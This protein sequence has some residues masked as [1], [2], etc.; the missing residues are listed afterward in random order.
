[1]KNKEN[2][3]A[4]IDAWFDSHADALVRDLGT[5]IAV[6]SVRG[7]AL[8]GKPYGEG[9][10]AAL[11]AAGRI[12]EEKGFK[13]VNF[14]NHVVTADLN[15]QE[16]TL[17]ILAHLDTVTV[18]E[19]WTSDPFTLQERGGALYG[20][21]VIDDKGPA[22]AAIHALEA[23][24]ALAPELTKGCRLILGSAEETGHDDLAFYRK[25]N[26]MP[27]SVFTPDA[28]YPVVNLEKGRFVPT[29]GAAWA[30]SSATPCVVSVTGGATA[31]VVPNHA[32]AVVEGLPLAY[33]Q[34]RC[35]EYASK[36]HTS[37]SAAA[38]HD[39]VKITASGVASHAMMP[40]EGLNAQTALLAV[41]SELPLHNCPALTCIK[42]LAELFPHG[43]TAGE[44]LG[45]AMRDDI[46]GPLTL[47]FGVLSLGPTGFTANFDCRSPKCATE[48]NLYDVTVR[49][50]TG[51]GFTVSD[52]QKTPCHHT[53]AE[54]PLVQTLLKVYED[55]TGNKGECISL[56]GQTYV[57]DI[58]GGVAFGPSFPG[59]D[60]RLHGADE[61]I[62]R[63][64]LILSAKMYTQ[65]II[66]MCS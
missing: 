23:A 35:F 40:Q 3:R 64:D 54:S 21:G 42:K 12:L 53:P 15:G 9:P 18:G 17:G 8:P 44:T 61:F 52:I 4:E 46:S 2:L 27:P 60:N 57:H 38:F 34:A 14:E 65:A 45:I 31:N 41:L 62:S 24:R 20:R 30:E 63:N 13:P 7:E 5:L 59:V 29:F 51:A 33:V 55:Y 25:T 19:S 36:F 1:M 6:N 58:D 10:A 56:G 22:V 39:G 48:E 47:N 49:A 32:E 16:P 28:D 11:A 50:L 37:I 43:D 26:K 66:D